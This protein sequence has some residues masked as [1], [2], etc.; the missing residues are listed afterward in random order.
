MVIVKYFWVTL[1]FF[2]DNRPMA[3][4]QSHSKEIQQGNKFSLFPNTLLFPVVC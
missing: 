4:Q 2:L 1:H 3:R